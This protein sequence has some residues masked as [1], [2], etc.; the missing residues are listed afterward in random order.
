MLVMKKPEPF[1][2]VL[3][4]QLKKYYSDDIADKIYKEFLEDYESKIN[5]FSLDDLERLT[6]N[7]LAK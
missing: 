6:E 4:K 7:L 3:L 2:D 5:T 1:K